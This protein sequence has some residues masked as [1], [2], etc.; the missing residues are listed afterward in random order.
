MKALINTINTLETGNNP[1]PFSIYSSTKEQNLLNVPVIKPLLIAILSGDK[2]LGED[3]DITC[4][5]GEFVFLS[6]TASVNMRN[7]PKQNSYHA[8]L[9]EFDYQD[10]E[11]LQINSANEATLCIGD[12][13]ETLAK[14]L[15]QFV[16]WSAWAP[17]E[18][19]PLRR[20]EIL[21]LL[22]HMGH[23][24]IL[25]MATDTNLAHQV[26]AFFS[27]Q[28]AHSGTL[29]SEYICHQLAMSESTLR[30]KLK[31]QNTTAQ[32]IK[33]QA[34]LG[35]GLHLLQSTHDAIGLIADQCGYQSQSRFT[36][37][38]KALFGLTP[39]ELRKTKLTD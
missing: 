9:I 14:C 16:E 22:C 33:D 34:R 20:K 39:S 29:S 4:T 18:L 32:E 23:K 26:H 1:L 19:W 3:T 36:E 28:L 30:R 15:E 17:V 8:L 25:S 11:N 10:F 5:A 38:F 12:I 27:D 31:S 21:Q 35:L 13:T 37:R 6:N 24:E 7:I 2:Q